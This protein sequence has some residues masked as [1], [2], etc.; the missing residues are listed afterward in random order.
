M[1]RINAIRL[2][3]TPNLEKI[4]E[5]M[6][7]SYVCATN[8][9]LNY[10]LADTLQR[11]APRQP[12]LI[13]TCGLVLLRHPDRNEYGSSWHIYARSIAIVVAMLAEW[14]NPC[15]IIR[16]IFT[17]N[18]HMGTHK[19]ACVCNGPIGCYMQL[20]CLT[21]TRT[22]LPRFF[23]PIIQETL[24]TAMP[25]SGAIIIDGTIILLSP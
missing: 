8:G 6:E 21:L 3:L 5:G 20:N 14:H 24:C 1:Q 19:V 11:L 25:S 4:G 16:A 12:Q 18:S 2:T 15:I 17:V 7:C 10:I 13:T 23:L 22:S 9:E